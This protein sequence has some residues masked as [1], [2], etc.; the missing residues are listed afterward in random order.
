MTFFI[1][2]GGTLIIGP[3]L[4]EEKLGQISEVVSLPRLFKHSY[5]TNLE[6]SFRQGGQIIKVVPFQGSTV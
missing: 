3:L 4:G 2:Y 1:Q 5:I 6:W